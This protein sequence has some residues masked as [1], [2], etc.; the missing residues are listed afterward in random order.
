MLLKNSKVMLETGDNILQFIPQRPPVVMVDTLYSCDEKG[1]TSGL[2]ILKENIFCEAG[3][4]SEAGI[5]ENIA[6]TAA[7][8]VGYLCKKNNVPVPI[9]FIGAVKNLEISS[10]PKAGD[11]IATIIQI[12]NE[13]FGITLISGKVLCN[14]EIVAT[15][16]MKIVVKT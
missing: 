5:I 9:G 15:A 7:M 2:T 6:Q 8:H 13:V 1:S 3:V 11:K 10:L 16:E 12:E 14:E 4:F